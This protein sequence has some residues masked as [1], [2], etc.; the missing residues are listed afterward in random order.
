MLG[1]AARPSRSPVKTLRIGHSPD[2]DDAFMFY[3]LASGAVCINGYGI[4]HVIADIQT[5]NQ[6]AL[7]GELEV[8][9]ISAHAYPYVADR[10]WIMSCG[11]SMGLGYGP[12][13]VAKKPFTLNEAGTKR[14]A[15]PG[16]LTTAALLS[17][18]YLGD[19]MTVEVPFDRIFEAIADGRVD[20][21]VL[22]HEGQVTYAERNL[23]KIADFGEL[24]TKET[25]GLPLPLGLDV[26]RSD[27]GKSLAKEITRALRKSI[28]FGFEHEKDAQTY[29]L[30]FGRGIEAQQGKRFVRMYVNDYTLDLGEPGKRALE[31]LF[32][33]AFEK[34]LIPSLPPIE[35]I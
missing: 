32:Q 10:Y 34:K 18:L 26:V 7:K 4:E 11:A 6:R 20:A 22:I 29:A 14:I 13:L 23:V 12:V 8:T 31:L 2:P 25:G 27:L 35:V 5:L 16:Q 33:R 9:A 21:G 3:G 1:G 28:R 17:K 24:W 15:I 30:K 19:F